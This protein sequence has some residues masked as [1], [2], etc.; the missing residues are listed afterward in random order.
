MRK[1]L[2]ALLAVCLFCGCAAAGMKIGFLTKLNISEDEYKDILISHRKT[3]GWHLLDEKHDDED[4]V[5]F[6]DSL[7]DL[8]MALNRGDIDEASLPKVVAEYVLNT[9]SDFVAGSLEKR[10]RVYL[11]FGF[12]ER[13]GS[14]LR[15]LFNEALWDMEADGTLSALQGKYLADPGLTEPEPV[16]IE[17]FS[18]AQTLRVAVTGDLP[19]LDILAADG[20][21]AGFNSA[22]LAEIGRRLHVNIALM[23]IDAGARSAALASGRAD[24]VFW[25]MSA[26]DYERD[27]DVP[28]GVLLSYPYY[29]WDK[30]LYLKKK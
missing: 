15:H 12:S 1:F 24:V 29:E 25:Y 18:D 23:N 2:C 8:Q 30:F 14:S 22:V 17:S 3:A 13:R 11:S 28:D 21:P 26:R 4:V 9:T 6:Y 19:P 5:V 10:S 16:K 7:V 27:I 20:T